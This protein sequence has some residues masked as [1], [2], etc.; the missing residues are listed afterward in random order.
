MHTEFYWGNVSE[1]DHL[2]EISVGR[3]IIINRSLRT[4]IRGR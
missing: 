3:K 2:E 1:S 4:R